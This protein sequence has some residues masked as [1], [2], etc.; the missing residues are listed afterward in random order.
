MKDLDLGLLLLFKRIESDRYDLIYLLDEIEVSN[1]KPL[2]KYVVLLSLNYISLS[3]LSYSI[4]E[5][6]LLKRIFLS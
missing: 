2:S 4:K 1:Y 5:Y 6:F 3:E